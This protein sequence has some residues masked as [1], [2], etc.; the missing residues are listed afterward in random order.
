MCPDA[1]FQRGRRSDVGG[2]GAA[3]RKLI[4]QQ[5]KLAGTSAES[6]GGASGYIAGIGRE[7]DGGASG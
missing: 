4:H 7:S 2:G 3:S 6:D 5:G 1:P